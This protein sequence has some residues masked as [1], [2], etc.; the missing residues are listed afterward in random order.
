MT[1]VGNVKE[2]NKKVTQTTITSRTVNK[3]KRRRG[4]LEELPL[5][6]RHMRKRGHS[7]E[8]VSAL[9]N[10]DEGWYEC[11]RCEG[12]MDDNEPFTESLAPD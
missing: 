4:G 7:G 6:K 5:G 9:S 1:G 8:L 11:M 10:Y 3:Q 12:R 2:Q